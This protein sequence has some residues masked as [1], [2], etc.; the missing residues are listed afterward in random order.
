ARVERETH[1]HRPGLP[2][3][4]LHDEVALSPLEAPAEA[5]AL[6]DYRNGCL[7]RADHR[8]RDPC[9]RV[10]LEPREEEDGPVGAPGEH[11]KWDLRGE[12]R[13]VGRRVRG[14]A[15]GSLPEERDG[16]RRPGPDG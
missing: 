8:A 12:S 15:P 4:G 14:V 5:A 6:A 11:P 9:L 13:A 2:A 3:I 10:H 1:L 16:A 7:V